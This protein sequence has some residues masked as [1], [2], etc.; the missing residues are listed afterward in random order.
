MPETEVVEWIRTKFLSLAPDLNERSRRMWAAVEAASLGHGG[1]S[2]VA[3]A[4]GLCRNTLR[5]GLRELGQPATATSL[6]PGRIRRPGGG[7]KRLTQTYPRL[8]AQL[9]ALLRP[10]TR[11]DPQSPLRWTCKSTR[12]L[13][14]ELGKRGCPVSYVTVDRM[15]RDWGYSLQSNR[16]VRQGAHHP[17]RNAQFEHIKVPVGNVLPRG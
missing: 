5:A 7:R 6:P 1:A 13:A 15:L 10:S 8:S 14:A 9:E 3:A 4:T 16:K 17:D 12:H 2:A 11:G